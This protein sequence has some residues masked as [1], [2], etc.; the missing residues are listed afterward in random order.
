MSDHML[1]IIIKNSD[2][3]L[4]AVLFADEE[5][6]QSDREISG[7]LRCLNRMKLT[8]RQE[9]AV[10]RLLTAYNEQNACCSRIFYE[11]GLRFAAEGA[12]S[13]RMMPGPAGTEMR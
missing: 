3:R 4:D 8:R 6:R 5:Y 9:R 2:R 10:D 7:R 1:D 11:Q 13:I 12:G